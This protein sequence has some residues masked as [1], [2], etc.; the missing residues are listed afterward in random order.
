MIAIL[1]IIG[2]AALLLWPAKPE[3]APQETASKPKRIRKPRKEPK[4]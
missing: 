1:C 3:P 2:A 4:P